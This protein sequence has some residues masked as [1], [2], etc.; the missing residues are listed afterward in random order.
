MPEKHKMTDEELTMMQEMVM[1]NEEQEADNKVLEDIPEDEISDLPASFH[2]ETYDEEENDIAIKSC[3]G[4]SLEEDKQLSDEEITD[5]D[6][7]DDEE[8]D[9][10]RLKLDEEDEKDLE[11]DR[12]DLEIRP[13]DIVILVAN[14]E[15]DFSNLEVQIY[16]EEN[17]SLYV[18]HEINLPDF[19]L[20]LSWMDFNP[21]PADPT[22]EL[23]SGSFV[24]V[25][26]FKPGIEI[27]N[28][29]I[30]DVLEPSAILGGEEESMRKNVMPKVSSK[31]DRQIRLRHGSHT[32]A[33]MSLDWNH[34]HRNM[35]VSGSADHTVKVWDILTQNCLHTMQHHTNKVQCVRWNP[36]ETTVLA[37]ASF[38]HRLLVLD[39]RHPDAFSSFPLSADVESIAWAPYQPNKL[40]AATEDGVVVCYDVRM[41]ASEPLTRFQAH[42]GTV[43]AVSFAAQIPGMFATAG[44]DKTVKIWDLLHFDKEPKCIAT[45]EMN[46]GGLYAMSFCID[47]PFLLGC[48]GASGT[49]ALWESSEKCVIEEHFQSR[50]QKNQQASVLAAAK[51]GEIAA[52]LHAVDT[53]ASTKQKKKKP[54]KK[55]S[56]QE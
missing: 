54:K 17:G 52:T 31:K 44:I 13:N 56:S 21:V 30:L 50:V 25:G 6:M 33:V 48:G 53:Q 55:R 15:D 24:A 19:P 22:K 47:T 20:C 12:E 27:W 14:T 18:H 2:M 39:G 34:T 37:T 36:S 26:T 29:D 28:L 9:V 42:A 43:S 8:I 51:V 35:L 7:Q 16:D 41:N 23:E 4:S 3:I 38:D 40:V 49:L 32:D 45:K 5:Q 10:S 11:L 46:V 1:E